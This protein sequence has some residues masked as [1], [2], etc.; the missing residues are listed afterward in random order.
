MQLWYWPLG[1]LLFCLILIGA[2]QWTAMKKL[3]LHVLDVI[4]LPV[5]VIAHYM[6]GYALGVSYIEWILLFWFA[7]GAILAWFL[8]Q[9][10]WDWRHFWHRYWQW[11]GLFGIAVI[12]VVMILG[13]INH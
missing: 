6:M 13:F 3:R 7:F 8:L 12:I 1:G 11:S 4:T 5:W 2:N 9:K 10:N